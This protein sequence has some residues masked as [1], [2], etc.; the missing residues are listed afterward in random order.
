MRLGAG[1]WL[2]I[3]LALLVLA[4]S[5]DAQTPGPGPLRDTS[6]AATPPTTPGEEATARA[7]P[8]RATATAVA[9]ADTAS[10]AAPTSTPSVGQPPADDETAFLAYVQERL[11]LG[12]FEQLR[13][14]MSEQFVLQ[15]YPAGLFA[16]GIEDSISALRFRFVVDSEAAIEIGDVAVSDLVAPDLDP[17]DLFAGPQPVTRV[18]A[19][20]GWGLA[21]SG[22]GLL[23]LTEEQGRLRWAG[24]VLA[25]EGDGGAP[26]A[27]LAE[28]QTVPPP[29]GLIYMVGDEW[30]ISG[31]EGQSRL[32][33]R[34]DAWLSLNPTATLAISTEI[35]A[36]EVTVLD[37]TRGV[38]ETIALEDTVILGARDVV[39][40]D[41]QT[42]VLGLAPGPGAVTQGTTGR[43][44]LLDV[45]SGEVTPIGPQIS[46]YA[47]PAA[48]GGA[49]VVDSNEGLWLWQDGAGRFL[50][51]EGLQVPQLRGDLFSPVLAP[52]HVR[53]AGVVGGDFGRQTHGYA[54][55]D[56]EA[57][58]ARLVHT[59]L[60]VP[61]D[62]RLPW[63]IAWSSDGQWLAL[64]PPSWDP[65][66]SGVWLVP[67][68][69]T[70]RRS[71]GPG[72]QNAVWLDG[73]R[74]AYTRTVNGVTRAAMI[75]VGTGETAWLELPDG[76]RVV[77][78]G[79]IGD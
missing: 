77:G 76:A 5:C 18:V 3:W 10:P 33:A 46:T 78:V 17:A 62:A 27:P 41:E 79:E 24:L 28:Q 25:H 47:H 23:Y 8:N 39:W 72:T 67:A 37:L 15:L 61:T 69:G 59:F 36:Q 31:E 75:D 9:A 22:V 44:A 38:S 74:L 26:F 55:V 51:L 43:L 32:L 49:L 2:V 42:A 40:L 34:H 45:R 64:E 50:E 13:A 65:V 29:A 7:T 1:F 6:P 11:N 19:S 48:S 4:V 71:L 68:H 52:D 60:P 63:G 35:E 56:R 30:R 20:R 14:A 57:G 58:M 66:E 73:E 70:E 53:L 12:Q 16:E 21:E 54:V